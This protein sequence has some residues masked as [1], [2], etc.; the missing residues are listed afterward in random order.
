MEAMPR[1]LLAVAAAALTLAA[2]PSPQ[3]SATPT[4]PPLIYHVL[5]RPVCAELHQHVR[6]A[7]GMMLQNDA[8]IKKS[9][10][11]FSQYNTAALYGNDSTASSASSNA[12]GGSSNAAQTIA[13]LGMENLVSPIAN[14]IIAIQKLLDSPGMTTGTGNP[15][16]DRQLQETRDKL[17]Q[18]LAV[19]NASLD[20][21]NGFVDTQ[22]M[23]DLQH[24]GQEYISE[25]T[26]PDTQE[27][28]ATPTPGP[29][30]NPNQAGLPPNPYQINL[31]T[32]PGLTLGYNPVTRLLDALNWT[33][34]QTST[35][36]DA[37]AAAV[38]QLK[39]ACDR[40]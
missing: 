24:A 40:Q 9:P 1:V 21:I 4:A 2:A 28:V 11:L 30:A 14:N 8:E 20:I 29:F 23:A 10:A 37:A 33:I 6:P 27:A 7:V 26:Q 13:L 34:A 31:A 19:Q 16:D 35:R 32:I 22:N 36:E 39:A 25:M 3:P 18:A 38:M 5:T 12:N 17:L 15:Q